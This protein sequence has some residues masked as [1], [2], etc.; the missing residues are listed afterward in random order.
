MLRLRQLVR[1]RSSEVK[2]DL[3]VRKIRKMGL[4]LKRMPNVLEY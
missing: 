1:D 2:G 4:A 3:E